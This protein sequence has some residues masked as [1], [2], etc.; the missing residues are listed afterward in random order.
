MKK[1]L[2]SQ[3]F[4]ELTSIYWNSQICITGFYSELLIFHRTQYNLI[5]SILASIEKMITIKSIKN[6]STLK[7]IHYEQLANNKQALT[8][9]PNKRKIRL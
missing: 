4:Q 3:G 5:S 9:E 7:H 8:Q 6:V 2:K 1:F